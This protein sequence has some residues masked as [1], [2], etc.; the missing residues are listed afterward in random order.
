MK[1]IAG[2]LVALILAGL[3]FATA[4]RAETIGD[5]DRAA[6]QSLITGQIEAF[7]ADNGA[8][9]Y[10][11]ASPTIQ[12]Y[13]PTADAFMA[14]VKQGYMPV[15]RPNAVAFGPL[16]DGPTGPVQK[17]FV[18]GPDGRS[19]IAAYS[20]QQQPDGSWKINGCSLVE[21]D[22]PSI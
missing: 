1:R 10:G 6:I 19:Y 11:Y 12:G 4:A 16:V 17:V 18:T 13:F 9:A 22:T 14:M 2:V 20:M 8:A 15:Y 7:R 3:A 5:T 21:D